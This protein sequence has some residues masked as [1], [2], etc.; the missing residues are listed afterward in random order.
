MYR[1]NNATQ[2]SQ[3]G[4]GVLVIDVAVVG[5]GMI[6]SAAARHL[7]D[8]GQS[9]VLI[10]PSEPKDYAQSAGPFSSHFDQGRI[11][12]ITD[13]SKLWAGWAKASIDR[14]P[15]IEAQSGIEFH[16]PVGLAVLSEY[17]H[18]SA[19]I[20]EA[21]GATV[22]KLSERQ[23]RDR[24]GMANLVS[25]HDIV[26]EGAPAGHINPRRLVEAQSKCAELNGATILD[27][28]V[29]SIDTS[30]NSV[31]I[32]CESG[33]PVQSTQVLLCTGAYGSGL[34]GADLPTERRL[35][36][37]ALAELDEGPELPA[38][39]LGENI[40]PLLEYAYWVPP[41]TFPDGKQLLKIGGASI[42]LQTA[43]TNDE[44]TQWFQDG[45][46]E[47]EAGALFDL[48][49]MLLPDREVTPHSFKPCVTTSTP[50]ESP[51][52]LRVSDRAAVAFG[53][54]GAAAKSSDELG[55][56]A[57]AIVTA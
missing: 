44:I 19:A 52:I 45:G 29:T 33:E 26:W 10:G 17:A 2:Y 38:M 53:G 12:R 46:S 27:D 4:R 20:G 39:I 23:L 54:C 40:H 3:N 36:T 49:R 13:G 21:L 32:R 22:E 7:S 42:P 8:A 41:V 1:C 6:G 56:L 57:A 35:R 48:M 16:Y 25:N 34:L 31:L 30:G 9:V 47:I 24:C 5:R 15:E 14:Y 28:I 51:H 18:S 11:T 55:R 50:Q 43:A 37:V